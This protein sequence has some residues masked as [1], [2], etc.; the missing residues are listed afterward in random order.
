MNRFRGCKVRTQGFTLI[1]LLVVIAIIAILAAILFPV[2]ARAREN[3]RRAS[4][5]SNEKQIGLALAQY[6]QD[7]DERCLP[8]AYPYSGSGDTTTRWYNL[9]DPYLKSTQVLQCPSRPANT[10]VAYGWNYF[11]VGYQV[12][13]GAGSSGDGNALGWAVHQ[14]DIGCPAQTIPVGD[15]DQTGAYPF[16]LYYTDSTKLPNLHLGGGNY[17]FFDGHVKWFSKDK[18]LTPQGQGLFTLDCTDN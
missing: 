5:Q 16:M 13:A 8:G 12:Q 14:N 9:L 7:Y 3:A 10:G 15:G 17:L 11:K 1:E 6:I 2:F 4:C 18:M